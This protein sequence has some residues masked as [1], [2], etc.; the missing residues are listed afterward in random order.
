MSGVLG[1]LVLPIVAVAVIIVVMVVRKKDYGKPKEADAT[2]E[3]KS[4]SGGVYT[5]VFDLNGTKKTLRTR[6]AYYAK[7]QPGQKGMLAYK[8]GTLLD[9]EVYPGS[10]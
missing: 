3:Q 6:E 5:Y 8:G 2:L 10:R 7:L 4:E 9:F 1:A